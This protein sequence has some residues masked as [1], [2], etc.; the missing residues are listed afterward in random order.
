MKKRTIATYLLLTLIMTTIQTSPLMAEPPHRDSGTHM[1]RG[2]GGGASHHM[3]NRQHPGSERSSDR[4]DMDERRKEFLKRLNLN[5]D[6]K[7]ALKNFR[8][9]RQEIKIEMQRLKLQ[10]MELMHLIKKPSSAESDVL[11]KVSEIN[12]LQAKVNTSRAQSALTLKKALS[13]EQFGRILGM[14]EK[15]KHHGDKRPPHPGSGDR[16]GPP[17]GEPPLL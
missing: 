13:E 14:L 8:E 9:E 16:H 15:M 11:A 3:M 4:G 1:R 10:G 5:E 17:A 2:Q 7:Q 6:Q 12:A